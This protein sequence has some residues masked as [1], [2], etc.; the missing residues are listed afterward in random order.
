MADL[1]WSKK[2]SQHLRYKRTLRY[3]FLKVWHKCPKRKV[4]SGILSGISSGILSDILSDILSRTL[5]DKHSDFLYGI[6]MHFVWK[7]IWLIWHSIQ[8]KVWAR[9]GPESCVEA[10]KTSWQW[11]A[12]ACGFVHSLFLR[13]ILLKSRNAHL[14]GGQETDIDHPMQKA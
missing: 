3:A 8:Y 5:F 1:H 6:L 9:R 4:S 13:Q 12:A 2:A 10:G 11:H 7:S 14:A